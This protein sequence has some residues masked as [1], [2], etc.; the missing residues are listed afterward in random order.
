MGL[1]PEHVERIRISALLHDIGKVVLAYVMPDEFNKIYL[2]A[3][4]EK[5]APALPGVGEARTT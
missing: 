4:L 5:K 3:A 1:S 2:Q